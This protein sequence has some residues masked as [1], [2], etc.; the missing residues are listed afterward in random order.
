[1]AGFRGARD[2]HEAERIRGEFIGFYDKASAADRQRLESIWR[3]S[4]LGPMR[5]AVT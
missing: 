4:D 5:G 3:E 2:T 1:V